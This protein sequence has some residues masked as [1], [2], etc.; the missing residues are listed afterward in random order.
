MSRSKRY[1][2][3]LMCLAAGGRA[4]HIEMFA[5]SFRVL[6]ADADPLEPGMQVSEG[7]IITPPFDDAEFGAMLAASIREHAVD[8]VMPGSCEAMLALDRERSRVRTAGAVPL[9]AGSRAAAVSRDRAYMFC[10]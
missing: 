9:V 5:R 7:G 6:T 3:T 8:V 1:K 10:F 4:A 2:P